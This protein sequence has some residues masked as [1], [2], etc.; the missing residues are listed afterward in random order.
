MEPGGNWDALDTFVAGGGSLLILGGAQLLAAG[1]PDTTASTDIVYENFEAKTYDAA[2]W[3][4]E[5][6]AF[7]TGPARGTLGSQQNVSGFGGQGLVN[8]YLNGDAATGKLT[9]KPFTIE[10]QYIHFLI[11]GGNHAGQTCINLRVGGKVART[12]V[13][14]NEEKLRPEKW[15]VGEFHGQMAQIE[16]VDTRADAWGH[17]NIDDIVFSD[18]I[19]AR[20]GVTPEQKAK[21][22]AFLPF[23]YTNVARP[24]GQTRAANDA[25]APVEFFGLPAADGAAGQSLTVAD[26]AILIDFHARPDAVVHRL[27]NG[28]P[29]AVEWTHGKGKAVLLLTGL[30]QW[31]TSDAAAFQKRRAFLGSLMARALA[32]PEHTFQSA[33]MAGEGLASSHPQWGSMALGVSGSGNVTRREQWDTLDAFWQDFQSDGRLDPTP[34]TPAEPGK[35]WNGAIASQ[36]TLQAGQETEIVFTL[37]WHFPNRYRDRTMDVGFGSN[38]GEY[39]VKYRLGNM[40]NNWFAYAGAVVAYLHK[41]DKR[42]YEETKR[43]HHS[44]FDSTL[45][46]VVRDAIS[47]QMCIPRTQTSMWIENGRWVAY[48]GLGCC[49]MNCTHVYNYAQTLAKLFPELERNVRDTDL[50]VQLQEDGGVRHRVQLP[51]D[52]PRATGPF[53][54]G[55]LSTICKAYR[56]HLQSA[57]NRFLNT[58]WP[59]VK[60][61][62][63]FAVRVYDANGDGLVEGRQPNTYDC[64]V[65]GH[66][67]FISSQYLAALRA[68]E[69]MAREQKEPETAARYHALYEKGRENCDKICWNGEYYQ[70]VFDA[71][72]T[73]PTQYGPGCHADQVLGQ[74]WA[75]VVGL[76]PILSPEKVKTALAAMMKHNFIADF[77]RWD[78]HGQRVFANGKDQGLVC[79]TWPRGGRPEKVAPILYC[80]EV[81]TGVEYQV[82]AHLLYEGMTEDALKLVEAV[83]ARYDGIKRNPWNEI[84]CSDHYGRAMASW[85]LLLAASGY[86]YHGPK[87]ILRLAP[88]LSPHDFR[89]LFTTAQGWG[90][91]TQTRP[92]VANATQAQAVV[93]NRQ[94]EQKPQSKTNLAQENTLLLDY[95]TL[96]LNEL[97]LSAPTGGNA[98]K[99]TATAQL[100]QRSVLT[101]LYQENNSLHLKFAHPLSMKAGQKLTVTISS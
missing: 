24:G 84:E 4:V 45:P 22:R 62:M 76:G 55:H 80:D 64:D 33:Q 18:S 30:E 98:A 86:E 35:T 20:S 1:L 68:A 81:W 27:R 83:R 51:L 53:T 79:C 101:T 40:Y 58:Y 100:A 23:T 78:Y 26:N 59:A 74:W 47:S 38:V 42:L 85:S 15:D 99:F 28:Q 8:T 72:L 14:H 29:F 21:I 57:D 52:V 70:Q 69:E 44:L 73:T 10:R 97:R 37:G 67:S 77:T 66:N 90:R 82:A 32:S 3:T 92:S 16:I 34:S 56:E 89:S 65:F 94:N 7:G 88:R 87:G 75:H 46:Y 61:A 36:F 6:D 11:G 39:E 31:F 91:F 25:D 12:E 60:K 96:T 5:G 50:T 95:G 2:K 13:G 63:D 41:N 19:I 17:I 9:S 49:P 54:D 71:Y 93:A 43:F 48:E